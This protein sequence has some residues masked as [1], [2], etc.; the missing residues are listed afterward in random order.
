MQ[1]GP[2]CNHM[3]LYKKEAEGRLLTHKKEEGHVMETE[4]SKVRNDAMLL[5]LKMKGGAVSQGMQGI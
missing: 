2:K 3:Y 1:V 4:G 5:N